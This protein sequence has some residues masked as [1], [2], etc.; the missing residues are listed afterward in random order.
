MAKFEL[1]ERVRKLRREG[2]PIN[3]IKNEMK[4]SKSTVSN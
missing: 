3:Q 1:K 4:L 2:F